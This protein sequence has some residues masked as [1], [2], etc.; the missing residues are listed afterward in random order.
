MTALLDA[1]ASLG[2]FVAWGLLTFTA[3]SLLSIAALWRMCQRAPE[4][5]CPEY[6][7]ALAAH[8][9]VRELDEWRKEGAR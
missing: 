8:N 9:A 1:L 3:V 5:P 6:D 2:P 7:P 4:D